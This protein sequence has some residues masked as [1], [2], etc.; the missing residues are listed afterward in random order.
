MNESPV[1]GWLIPYEDQE[2]GC[3][4]HDQELEDLN[5]TTNTEE[6]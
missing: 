5:N 6:S 4:D 3:D 2:P 1:M